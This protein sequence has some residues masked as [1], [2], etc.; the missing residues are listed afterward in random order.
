MIKAKCWL[1]SCRTPVQ[2]NSPP[3]TPPPQ[4]QRSFSSP[5]NLQKHVTVTSSL[6][7][8]TK[9]RAAL[10]LFLSNKPNKWSLP[11]VFSFRWTTWCGSTCSSLSSWT[12]LSPNLCGGSR[13]WAEI[14][15]AAQGNRTIP[16]IAIIHPRWAAAEA[17]AT[18]TSRAPAVISSTATARSTS[19]R[20]RGVETAT[21]TAEVETD[22]IMTKGGATA[23][24]KTVDGGDTEFYEAFLGSSPLFS[25]DSFL[26]DVWVMLTSS[27]ILRSFVHGLA[28]F[29]D[30]ITHAFFFLFFFK[31]CF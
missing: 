30:L 23:A 4:M 8:N 10:L 17:S 12:A 5:E 29:E 9:I 16:Y 14:P 31:R 7:S 27:C 22:N 6:Y 11:L 18:G 25:V 3:Y 2:F 13:P 28:D 19:T 20:T 26:E 15:A 1:L 21:M 24:T